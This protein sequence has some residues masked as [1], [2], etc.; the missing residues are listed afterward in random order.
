L[1]FGRLGTALVFGVAVLLLALRV[2]S[3][4]A[5]EGLQVSPVKIDF[6]EAAVGS[7]NLPRTVTITNPTKSNITMEQIIT[8][9][10][11]FSQKNDCGQ[12]LAPGIQ[13]TIQVFFTPATSGPRIGNLDVMGSDPAS[14]HFIALNGIGIN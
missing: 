2:Y 12:T 8:S 13:C 10:I 9:G 5:S 7:E 1:T 11:D 6:G 3:Q 14:P 4:T